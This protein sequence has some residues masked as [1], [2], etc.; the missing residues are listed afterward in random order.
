M[1]TT[2]SPNLF[3]RSVALV[4]GDLLVVDGAL[5]LVAGNDNFAQALRVLIGTPFGSDPVNVGYGL[6]VAAIFQV[7]GSVRSI[8]ETIRLNLVKS[9]ALDDRVRSI[10]DVVFDDEPGF[11]ALEPG[12]GGADPGTTA[13][14][15]RVWHALVSFSTVAGDRLQINV[16]GAA[17]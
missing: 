10:D 1:S 9:L 6:D 16:S 7:A 15:S 2:N 5:Q 13:R 17:T 4:D 11:A 14:R 8:K 3:G 12:L